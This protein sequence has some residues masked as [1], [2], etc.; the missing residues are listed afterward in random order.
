MRI[1]PLVYALNFAV[2]ILREQATPAVSS[3]PTTSTAQHF[4]TSVLLQEQRDE[5]RPLQNIFKEDRASQVSFSL[6]N[7]PD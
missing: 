2:L 5:F 6:Y 1:L 4:P 7:A 3:I